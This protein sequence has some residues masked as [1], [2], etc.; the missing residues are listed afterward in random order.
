MVK[1]TYFCL[2]VV[3]NIILHSYE[4]KPLS[5]ATPVLSSLLSSSRTTKQSSSMRTTENT[6]SVISQSSPTS[7]SSPLSKS[8]SSRPTLSVA[9]SVTISTTSPLSSSPPASAS[10]RS[11][12][13]TGT[14]VIATVIP[15]FTTSTTA[16]KDA[17]DKPQNTSPAEELVRADSSTMWVHSNVG[18]RP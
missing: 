1:A 16:S 14:P 4:G 8:S 3:S 2:T 6:R 5:L 7:L 18:N 10:T 13:I 12:L 9:P 15:S 11:S 17:N